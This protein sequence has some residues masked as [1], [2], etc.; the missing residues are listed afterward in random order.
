[1]SYTIAMAQ[2][3]AAEAE[4]A[5]LRAALEKIEGSSRSWY[6]G[7]TTGDGHATCIGIAAAALAGEGTP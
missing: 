1:M 6:G 3:Q 2:L 7:A 4:V 5:R